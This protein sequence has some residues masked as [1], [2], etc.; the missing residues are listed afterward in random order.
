MDIVE[1]L[2]ARYK[3]DA[4]IAR[5]AMG[6]YADGSPWGPSW[7]YDREHFRVLIDGQTAVAAKDTGD[8]DGA[9]IAHWD[10]ARVLADIAAKRAI[11]AEHQRLAEDY[12]RADLW[13]REQV[14]ALNLVLLRFASLY[15]EHPDFDPSWR[16][17]G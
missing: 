13:R 8:A 6:R 15:A 5:T 14:E 3:E 7:T 10:P 16:I 4:A 17:D 12:D 9:H 2:T 1:F 11:V